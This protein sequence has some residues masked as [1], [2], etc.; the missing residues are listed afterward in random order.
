MEDERQQQHEL[1]AALVDT[2]AGEHRLR[3]EAV[4]EQR[5]ADQWMQRVA[6]A[7]ERG[8]TDLAEGARARASRHRRLA[9]L[10]TER[11]EEIRAEVHRL[12]ASLATTAG[13]GRAPPI[14]SL[15]ARLVDLEL[16]AELER[17]RA[18]K[19]PSLTHPEPEPS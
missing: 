1:Q 2:L 5:T 7:E 16:E 11:A 17:L 12:R 4:R 8:L 3:R 9:R 18:A 19:R 14:R 13:A 10:L 15:E 6:L